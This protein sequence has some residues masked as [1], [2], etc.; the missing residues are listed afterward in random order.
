[1]ESKYAFYWD[2]LG[3]IRLGRPH[4]GNSTHLEVYRLMQFT[5]Q[6]VIVKKFDVEETD[7]IFYQAGRLA[8][9]HFYREKIGDVPELG[10]FI[11]KLTTIMTEMGIGI[12]TERD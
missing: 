8:G 5:L 6:D 4:L 1:M 12:I 10:A 9:N 7:D 3:D 2:L 11:Q